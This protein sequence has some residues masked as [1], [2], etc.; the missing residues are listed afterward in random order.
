MRKLLCTL[1]SALQIAFSVSAQPTHV[2][3]YSPLIEKY[4]NI[5]LQEMDKY[6]D[7]GMSIALVDGD[8]IVWCEGFGHYNKADKQPVTGHTPFHIGSVCKVFTGLA[9]MQLQEKEKIDIDKPFFRYVPAFRMKSQY[10]SARNITTRMILSHHAGIPDFIKDKFMP[11]QPYFTGVL[12]HVN[13]DYATFAPN[14]IFSYSNAGF[15]ILGNLVEN[16]S[17]TSYYDYMRKNILDPL[18]MRETGFV[19]DTLVPL[20]VRLG[21]NSRG[22]ERLEQP[23]Y[24]APAG[25]LYSTAYDMAKFIIAHTN[26]G[27]YGSQKIFDSVTLVKMMENQSAQVVLD[28]GKPYGLAWNIYYNDGGKSIQH[29]GGTLYHRAEL[30]ISPYAKMGVIIL[31]NSSSGKPLLHADYDILNEAIRIKGLHALPMPLT[32]KNN[33]SEN[34]N[35]DPEQKRKPSLRRVSPD[36]LKQ[37]EGS[38]GTFGTF[39]KVTADSDV[40]ILDATGRKF[41]LLPVEKDLFAA[42]TTK[43]TTAIHPFNWYYFEK[44]EEQLLLVQLDYSGY[45]YIA[46]EKILPATPDTIWQQRLGK[47]TSDGKNAYQVFSAFELRYTDNMFFLSAKF[48]MDFGLPL[49]VFMPLRIINKRLAKV[50]GYGRLSGQYIQFKKTG[51]KKEVMKFMGF[52]CTQNKK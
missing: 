2:P 49:T 23:V 37:Y 25:C 44:L 51:K 32:H 42:T 52:E 18:Q 16:V 39:Y 20:S 1:L 17:R 12:D 13:A 48:N 22:E 4:R 41:Y 35:L 33:I 34:H 36:Q 45:H 28:F 26:W 19:T 38:Y 40:L 11:V 27:M 31:S 8:S 24:D 50:Y 10:G 6:H 43:D 46:G 14:T 15:S 30:S 21:Y 9:V 47:Y 5:F 29:D 7:A 3:D